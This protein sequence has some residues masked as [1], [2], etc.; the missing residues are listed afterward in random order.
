MEARIVPSRIPTTLG[1]RLRAA[2]A[3]FNVSDKSNPEYWDRRDQAKKAPFERA[4]AAVP[5][6]D[7]DVILKSGF[8]APTFVFAVLAQVPRVEDQLVLAEHIVRADPS[9]LHDDRAQDWVA[10]NCRAVV[11]Y[12]ARTLNDD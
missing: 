9:I 2:W 4:L 5:E 11:E 3:A 10:R 7:R 12:C 6:A 8:Y 1:D